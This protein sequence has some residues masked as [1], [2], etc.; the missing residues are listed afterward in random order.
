M[1]GRYFSSRIARR[2]GTTDA[3]TRYDLLLASIPLAYALCIVV[4]HLTGTGLSAGLRGGSILALGA[5]AYALFGTPP[6]TG[7][8]R[9]RVG[10]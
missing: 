7:P 10:E 8:A 3:V 6:T 9:R 1:P 5:T 2:L 4:G